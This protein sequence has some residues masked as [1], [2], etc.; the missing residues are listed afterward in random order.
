M[1]DDATSV[2]RGSGLVM[3][4]GMNVNVLKLEQLCSPDEFGYGMQMNEVM[5]DTKDF[6]LDC[7]EEFN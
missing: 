7:K 1:G 4:G 6:G 2:L 5:H 3:I